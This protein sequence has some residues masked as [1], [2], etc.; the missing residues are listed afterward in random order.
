MHFR[1]LLSLKHSL[2][3]LIRLLQTIDCNIGYQATRVHE[4]MEEQIANVLNGQKRVTFLQLHI[5]HQE[6]RDSVVECL[7]RDRGAAGSSLNVSLRCGP[8]TRHIYPSFIL[9][10]PRK[11]CPC[12][13]ERLLMGHKESNK[14]KKKKR[15]SK[16]YPI[17]MCWHLTL[18]SIVYI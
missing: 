2:W 5:G 9:F 17:L 10:Q 14:K 13:T 18:Y 12:L 6:R 15:T 16:F 1:L 8:W 7:T 4:Q 11:T 3:I